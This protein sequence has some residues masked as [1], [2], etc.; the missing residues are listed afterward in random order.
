[1]FEVVDGSDG[2]IHK[3]NCRSAMFE[4]N[5]ETWRRFYTIEETII[6]AFTRYRRVSKCQE[7]GTLN[8][9]GWG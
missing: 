3:T 6:T 1:M 9:P 4:F 7:C 2:T 5:E 8:R